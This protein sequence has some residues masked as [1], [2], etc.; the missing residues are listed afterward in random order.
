[1][2]T[3]A[4]KFHERCHNLQFVLPKHSQTICCHNIEGVPSKHCHTTC[5]RNLEIDPPGQSQSTCCHNLEFDPPKHYQTTWLHNLEF[6]PPQHSQATC[7]HNQEVVPWNTAR[8]HGLCMLGNLGYIHALRMCNTSCF[9][10]ASVVMWTH[11]SVK[12][13]LTLHVLLPPALCVFR[14]TSYC[15]GFMIWVV[16]VCV[17]HLLLL[18]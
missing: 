15:E 12:F 8:L 18:T 9:S 17:F 1:V 16:K 4:C 7:C 2:S 13:I 14:W 5:F 6:V 11:L 10:M 3:V